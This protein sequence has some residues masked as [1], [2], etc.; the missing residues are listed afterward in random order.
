[1]IGAM[2]SPN[3]RPPVDCRPVHHRPVHRRHVLS[4]A[5]GA[6]LGLAGRRAA[7][8][9]AARDGIDTI[10]TILV[11]APFNLSV[12]RKGKVRAILTVVANLDV[13]DAA[14]RDRIA[15]ELPRVRDAYL[16][17]LDPYVDR[18][19]TT[20]SLD[21]PRLTKILQKATDGLYGSGQASVLITHATIRR[22]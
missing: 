18:L 2:S 12:V 13:G 9:E 16:R 5:L 7:R 10:G 21:V 3:L 6:A 14:L 20:S 8:A 15:R 19:D 4:L 11:L 22:V 17:G 1:M